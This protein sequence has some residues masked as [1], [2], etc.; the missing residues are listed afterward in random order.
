MLA[1]VVDELKRQGK[2]IVAATHELERLA[3]EF[4]GSIY[5]VI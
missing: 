5:F 1:K 3:E 4:D 2:T